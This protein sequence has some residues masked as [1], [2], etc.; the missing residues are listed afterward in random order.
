[1]GFKH[2]GGPEVSHKVTLSTP[3]MGFRATAQRVAGKD[4]ALSTPLMGFGGRREGTPRED[5]P[6]NSLNGIRAR[7]ASA[8]S[9][10]AES[11]QLP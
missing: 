4:Y 8:V 7:T 9:L 1:M 11:F 5:P 10:T 3:L 6:F 2:N